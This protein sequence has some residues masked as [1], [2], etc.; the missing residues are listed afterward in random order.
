M[1]IIKMP[2]M[3]CRD[4]VIREMLMFFSHKYRIMTVVKV[5]TCIITIVTASLVLVIML[6]KTFT[7]ELFFVICLFLKRQI[8]IQKHMT[9]IYTILHRQK[10]KNI[11]HVYIQF[12]I[13]KVHLIYQNKHFA[14]LHW[15]FKHQGQFQMA[16]YTCIFFLCRGNL[17]FSFLF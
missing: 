5:K 16:T 3:F 11:W 8:Q 17:W 14:T 4:S 9:C 6:V 1:C 2:C 10:T 7:T 15:N 12:Y 13:D